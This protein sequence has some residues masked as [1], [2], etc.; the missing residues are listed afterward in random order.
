MPSLFDQYSAGYEAAMRH[1][2]GFLGHDHDFFTTAKTDRILALLRRTCNNLQEL[3]VLD[4]GCGV[5]KTDR[6]LAHSLPHLVGLDVSSESI[7]VAQR[8]NPTVRYQVYDGRSIPFHDG[9]FD[10]VFAICVFH[11]VAPLDRVP[12]LQ[13]MRRVLKPDGILMIFEHNPF[14]P[15]TR[16][17]VLRCEF[18][19][20]AQLL[21]RRLSTRLLGQ[22]GLMVFEKRYILTVPFRFP[23]SR[24]LEALFYQVPLGAQYYVAAR[25]PGGGHP[26]NP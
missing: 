12:L 3:Q 13:E 2:N 14:N 5:G 7:A 24:Q 17:S 8:S 18:D 23:G 11:H 9:A 4:L 26:R 20:D 15:L 10:V 16:L 19:R 21:T 6:F 25:H 1:A 22:A